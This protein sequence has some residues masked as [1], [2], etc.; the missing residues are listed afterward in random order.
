MQIRPVTPADAAGVHAIYAP[1]VEHTVI[2]FELE[3]PT[4]D[5][6]A[7]RI[8]AT[9]EKYPWLVAV[10]GDELAGYAYATQYRARPAYQWSVEVSCYI[11]EEWRGRGLGRALYA[12]LFG[13]LAARQFHRAYAGIALPNEA[14]VALHERCGFTS[15]G[16][17][18]E[19]GFKFRAWRDVGW[20]ERGI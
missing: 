6:I 10:D 4:I 9:T 8:A 3:P 1:I 20:W 14:S 17:F 5:E 7:R 2:S 18:H 12:D 16:V 11:H 19:A 13:I 15:I